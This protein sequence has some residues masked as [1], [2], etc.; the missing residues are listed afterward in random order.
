[1][2][3][4]V[5]PNQH[6]YPAMP[7]VGQLV[8]QRLAPWGPLVLSRSPLKNRTPAA[9]RDRHYV[10]R[11]DISTSCCMSPCRSDYILLVIW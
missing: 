9:D 8:H 4:V 1:M 11:T 10:T 6:S 3:S 7:L 2:L 5:I